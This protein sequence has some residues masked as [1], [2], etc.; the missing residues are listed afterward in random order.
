[1]KK[2]LA[3]LLCSFFLF[4]CTEVPVYAF[5]IQGEVYNMILDT[6]QELELQELEDGFLI[7]GENV[8]IQGMFID[9]Q[10]F[11]E[12]YKTILAD[13]N[14]KIV[15]KDDRRLIWQIDDEQDYLYLISDQ[16]AVLMGS[17]NEVQ[18]IYQGISFEKN[19]D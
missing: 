5:E 15:E 2:V 1:M 6:N 18:Q 14:A 10:A 8:S 4:G 17:L 19:L 7:T 12:Y 13:S 9:S 11:D 3:F 16:S